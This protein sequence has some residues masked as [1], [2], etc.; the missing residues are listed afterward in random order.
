MA[1]IKAWA[2]HGPKEKLVPYEFD[3]G[4]LKAEEVELKVRYCGLC[5]SDVSVL[6]NDWG[7]SVYPF[8]PGHEAVG[9]ITALGEGVRGLKIG[10][11]VGVG[12]NAVSCMHCSQCISGNHHLCSEN[13][14]TIIGHN[15][16]FAEHLRA[17]WLWVFPLPEKLDARLTGPLMCGGITVFSPFVLNTIRPTDHV[18]IVGLGGLGHMAVRFARAWG[19]EVTAFTHSASKHDEARKLGADHVV[20]STD[21]N[22][23]RTLAGKLDMLLVTVNVPLDWSA[24][25]STV[26]P[27]GHLHIVGAVLEPIPV[28]AFDL[29]MSQRKVTGSPTG[30]PFMISKMLNF[31]ARHG[32]APQVEHFPLS[33]INEAFAHL[34][35]GKARYRI[36][37]DADF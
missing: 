25:M 1:S 18:G 13:V 32:I 15:G 23:V 36:V 19:C 9:E 20:V 31:A 14:A 30:S 8:V 12:W 29:I 35:A 10:Q 7:M 2:A 37:L 21:S 11:S 22:A 4:P 16:G 26:A 33:R 6:N 3:P 5:H 34:E 24:F 28:A 17:H 27:N